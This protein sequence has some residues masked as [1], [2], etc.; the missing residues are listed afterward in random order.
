VLTKYPLPSST[1]VPGYQFQM[2]GL[3]GQRAIPGTNPQRYEFLTAFGRLSKNASAGSAAREAS[4]PPL[5]TAKVV[6]IEAPSNLQ[7]AVLPPKVTIALTSDSDGQIEYSHRLNGGLWT[8]FSA[9]NV[10]VFQREQLRLAGKHTLEVRARRAGSPVF[11]NV[12]SV[13]FDIAASSTEAP[14]IAPA[15]APAHSGC[16][17]ATPSLWLVLAGLMLVRIRRRA[18]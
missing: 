1:I 18:V 14:V 4:D 8:R 15:P 6:S 17:A 13:S 5:A 16:A 12:T 3:S 2:L 10:R 11:G 7:D 9:D